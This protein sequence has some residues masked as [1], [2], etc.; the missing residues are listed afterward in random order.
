MISDCVVDWETLIVEWP[1]DGHWWNAIAHS[2]ENVMVVQA[3]D[4]VRNIVLAEE[5]KDCQLSW[6][7]SSP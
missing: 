2:I 4:L 3:V 5:D 6:K 7:D 1:N